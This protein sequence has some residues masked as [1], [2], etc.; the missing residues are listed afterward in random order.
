MN[1]EVY[2]IRAESG[3]PD[4]QK[5]AVPEVGKGQVKIKVTA[6]GLNRADLVQLAGQYQPPSGTTNVLGL[7]C[8]GVVVEAGELSGDWV[9]GQR[10][11]ALLAGGGMATEVV[12]DHRQLLPIPSGCSMIEAASLMETFST[13]WLNLFM[14]GEARK[15]E[16]ALIMAGGS[17][18]GVAAVQ[19]CREFG[20]ESTVVVGSDKKLAE[21]LSL[22]A[23]SGINRNRQDRLELKQY[24]AF[25]LVL[26]C[27]GGDWL[28]HHLSLMA[29]DGRLINIGF[30]AGRYGKLDFARVLMKRLQ[31][32]GST[33]RFLSVER[34][35]E[36]LTDLHKQVWPLI[37]KGSIQ[38]VLDQVFSITDCKAAFAHLASNQ[39]LGKVI[40]TLPDS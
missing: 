30:M 8:S 35:Q 4:W 20:V 17:G 36:I 5:I 38:P 23:Q 12:C 21:C 19:L 18:V 34:K 13:A 10:V 14:L 32:R 9:V 37:D 7:E 2:G 40:L 11:C 25:D 15:G 33:L 1:Q 22:G 24:G 16:K 31:I 28:E 29:D 27:C 6:A 26:D 3:H 39:T